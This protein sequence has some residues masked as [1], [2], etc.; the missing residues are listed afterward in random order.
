MCVGVCACVY[1][2]TCGVCACKCIYVY[3]CLYVCMCIL[4]HVAELAP[5]GVTYSRQML[6]TELRLLSPFHILFWDVAKLLRL[7]LSSLCSQVTLEL[8]ILLHQFF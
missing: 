8:V 3:V 7:D 4:V 2:C 1:M 6:C 5:K